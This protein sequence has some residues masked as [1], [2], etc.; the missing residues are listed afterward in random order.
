MMKCK[1]H[2]QKLEKMVQEG[3]LKFLDSQILSLWHKYS[4][5]V[6]YPEKNILFYK[7][8]HAIGIYILLKG[9][10]DIHYLKNQK[11]RGISIETPVMLGLSNALEAM[12]YKYSVVTQKKSELIFFPKN[13]LPKEILRRIKPLQTWTD[14]R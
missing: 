9:S 1:T 5:S 12:P 6:L 2:T 13:A 8:H 11:W 14:R 7:G 4:E 10:I 3:F